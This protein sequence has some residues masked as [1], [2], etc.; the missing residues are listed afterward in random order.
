MT[1]TACTTAATLAGTVR[2]LIGFAD[3]LINDV[4]DDKFAHRC[5]T[6]INHPAFVLGHCAYYAGVCMQLLGGEIELS[7]AD[8]DRYEHGV[9]CQCDASQYPTKDEAV[10]AFNERMNTV[11]DFIEGCDESVFARSAEDTFFKGRV[12]NMGGV[13]TFML[14][15][16]ITFHL[17]QVSGWRRVAGMGS[18]S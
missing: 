13:A 18:A 4:E 6:T 8:K 16:H 15:G 10:A 12:P 3:M 7:E 17:G 5:G 1:T 11:A 2:F 14:V 9:E